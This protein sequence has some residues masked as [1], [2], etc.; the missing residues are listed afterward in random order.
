RDGLA[1]ATGHG[2]G[3]RGLQR[4]SASRLLGLLL[5]CGG[6]GL[7]GGRDDR[8]APVGEAPLDRDPVARERRGDLSGGPADEVAARDPTRE[9]RLAHAER[10]RVEWPLRDGV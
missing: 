8:S 3:S 2:F 4:R 1:R 6:R 9:R 5:W 7:A 10:R